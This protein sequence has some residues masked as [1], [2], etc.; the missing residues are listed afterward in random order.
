MCMKRV[1][2]VAA[3]W[4]PVPL[5]MVGRVLNAKQQMANMLCYHVPFVPPDEAVIKQLSNTITQYVASSRLSEDVTIRD[6]RGQLVLWPKQA[7]ASLPRHLGGFSVPDLRSQIVSLEAKVV[8][9]AFSPG[10]AGS[11]SN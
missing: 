1:H 8:A 2:G 9:A 10:A 5:S 7:I 11:G 6:N 3:R 4:R